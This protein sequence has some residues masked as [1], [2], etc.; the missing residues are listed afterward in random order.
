MA[1][2][3]T[4]KRTLAASAAVL[5]GLLAVPSATAQVADPTANVYLN[6][7]AGPDTVG[8]GQERAVPATVTWTAANFTCSEEAVFVVTIGFTEP[9]GSVDGINV[10]VEPAELNFTVGSGAH[11][12]TDGEAVNQ[13]GDATLTVE[14]GPSAPSLTNHTVDVTADFSAQLPEACAATG[15]LPAA[16]ATSAYTLT[17]PEIE[18]DE[19]EASPTPTDTT[20]NQTDEGDSPGLGAASAV[21]GLVAVAILARRKGRSDPP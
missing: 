15:D 2:M 14:V 3:S 10:S 8:V 16:S 19:P 5:V 11:A 6:M 12:A 13:T 7:A 4:P 1:T 21:A 9:A 18:P 17:T 20:G